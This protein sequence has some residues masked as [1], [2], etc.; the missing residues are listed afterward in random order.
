MKAVKRL[1]L[2]LIA[3][4]VVI[5]IF[6]AS[7]IALKLTD[8]HAIG[9][10]Q[11]KG[12]V[13]LLL[14]SACFSLVSLAA[15]RKPTWLQSVIRIQ[16]VW[17]ILFVTVLLMLTGGISSPYSFLYLLAIMSA[18]M[19]LDRRQAL[20]TA[21][22]CTILY[23]AMVDMQYYDLLQNLGLGSEAA[24]QRG[25][26][27][28]F[29]TIFLH[30]IGFVLAAIMASH[31]AERVRVSEVNLAELR[32][33]H[34]S[35]VQNLDSGLMTITTDGMVR[36]FNTYLEHLTGQSQQ[37]AYN[38]SVN[39]LFEQLPLPAELLTS[40]PRGEFYYP[41][42]DGEPLFIGYVAVPFKG[43]KDE[44][45]GLIITIK[46][47]TLIKQ[48]EQALKRADRLA[49]LGE[50]SA[51]MAHEIRNPL[52][53]I[54]G[55]IQLLADHDILKGREESRLYDIIIRESDRLNGL[56]T[57]FLSYARPTPPKKSPFSLH[58]LVQELETLLAGD[59]LFAKIRLVSSIPSDLMLMAD[60]GQIQQVLLNLL[61]NAADAMQV[62]GGEISLTAELQSIQNGSL[63]S[64]QKMLCLTVADQGCGFD[65]MSLQHL[66]EPF[67]TTKQTG[68][69]LGL[70]TVYR[71]IEA[72][73]GS[74]KVD[75]DAGQGAVVTILLPVVQ[76]V[77]IEQ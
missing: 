34:S 10:V 65:E 37:Q 63:N 29:Y 45:S 27:V 53:A 52:A 44:L 72:H 19:L 40:A 64:G 4:L 50:L 14:A 48:M 16:T 21:A 55:S 42:E 54:S 75:S 23:G 58:Q 76:E 49:A 5:A 25:D 12:I 66:F 59:E 51:R 28:L 30:L 62:K 13:E 8:S 36:V 74:I 24:R 56:I 71:I 73:D 67:W 3:R 9:A 32:Q 43:M 68:S 33:L 46:D 31:L 41:V 17:D 38:K 70:A 2:F 11:F 6:L 57:D 77:T 39:S 26:L 35:V 7:T 22:L 69:G 20:Y 1:H 18:G 60:Q 61:R 15:S 47:L